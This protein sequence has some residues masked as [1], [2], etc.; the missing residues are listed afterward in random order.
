MVYKY[1]LEEKSNRN[2]SFNDIV[3]ENG[4]CIL[5]IICY[6]V[7]SQHKYPFLQFM[8]EKIPFCN[9]I[10][11]EQLTFPYIIMR[12][13]ECNISE[14][15]L[16]K[17]RSGLDILD[18]NYNNISDDM[19]KGIIFGE[20]G[21]TPYALVDITGIDIYGLNFMRQTTCWFVL[22]S[23]IINTKKVCN[24]EIDNIVTQLFTDIPQIGCLVNCNTNEY[25]ILPD[26]V[27]TGCEIK[28]SE[29]YSIFGN[30]KKKI[31]N[32]CGEYYFFYRSFYDAVKDGG[33]LTEGMSRKIG[34]RPLVYDNS[35]KYITGCINR[36]ALFV[37][38]KLYLEKG[39]E[40]GITDDII[41]S[42]YP[43]PCI[44]ICYS[45]EH[46]IKPDMLVKNYESFISL[47]YHK[48]NSK[49]LDEYFVEENKKQYMIA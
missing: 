31:Y 13:S 49:T 43:E 47:S 39:R 2:L 35:N 12:D 33:W 44:I 18:C 7:E 38:G 30:I 5:N 46:D 8:M 37:E 19:Y 14:K 28:T 9:N 22:P 26:A 48:L 34:D 23:E 6:H 11:K 3:N 41:E 29:F 42:L 15:I 27:Y 32:T 17:V 21:T 40:F 24:I 25:Y 16:E 45:G 10:V 1:L 36:Y 20:D 4:V